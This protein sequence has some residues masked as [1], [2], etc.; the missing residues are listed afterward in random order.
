MK[1]VIE[2]KTKEKAR[3]IADVLQNAAAEADAGKRSE[4]AQDLYDVASQLSVSASH[5]NLGP[6][7]STHRHATKEGAELVAEHMRSLTNARVFVE[8]D[9][10]D[11]DDKKRGVGDWDIL[12]QNGRDRDSC[13]DNRM[14][15]CATAGEVL[16]LADALREHEPDH[17]LLKTWH[18]RPEN[19]SSLPKYYA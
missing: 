19:R 9:P 2:I 14:S 18:L 1:F 4:S 15:R 6:S 17:P 13:C 5:L 16:A 3:E 10:V 11:G 12:Y 7:L 8:H